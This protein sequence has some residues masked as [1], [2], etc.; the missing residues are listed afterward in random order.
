[1]PFEKSRSR[2]QEKGEIKKNKTKILIKILLNS[3]LQLPSTARLIC[4]RVTK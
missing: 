3:P 4:L 2:G 1:M